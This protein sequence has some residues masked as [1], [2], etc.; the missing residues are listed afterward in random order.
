MSVFFIWEHSERIKG[1]SA[2]GA[3]RLT[4]KNYLGRSWKHRLLWKWKFGIW[5][6]NERDKSMQRIENC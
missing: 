1:D 6:K 4:A 3:G 5:E 2:L